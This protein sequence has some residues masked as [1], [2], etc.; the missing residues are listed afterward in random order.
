MRRFTLLVVLVAFTFSS[1]GQW[2]ILQGVAWANMIREYSEM[3]PVREAVAMTF[4]GQYPC[5]LCKAIAERKQADNVKALALHKQ[6]KKI[7][8]ALAA[9]SSRA[10]SVS[11][12]IFLVRDPVFT[13]RS[14]VPPTPPPRCA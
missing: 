5:A 8:S 7:C 1:G 6:E 10:V 14:D 13:T 4:S 12:Q 3:V 2:P 11:S 9:V